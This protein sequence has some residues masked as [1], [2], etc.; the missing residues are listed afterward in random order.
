MQNISAITLVVPDYDQAIAF[1]VGAL[2]FVLKEDTRLS[3]TKRWVVVMPPGAHETGLLLAKAEGDEQMRAVGDQTGGRVFLF[4]KTDDFDGDYKRCHAAGV[5]FL[6][7][8]RSETYGK[9]AMFQDPFG[10]RWDLIQ[11]SQA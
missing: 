2:G 7:C 1:Y 4:L 8:P 11:P 5:E 9:V 6:E 3:A 10:N